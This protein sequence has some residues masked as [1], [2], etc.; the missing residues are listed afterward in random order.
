MGILQHKL[1]AGK[2]FISAGEGTCFKFCKSKPIKFLKSKPIWV[3]GPKRY[4]LLYGIFLY[5]KLVC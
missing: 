5:F 4:C 3:G 2:T 1:D